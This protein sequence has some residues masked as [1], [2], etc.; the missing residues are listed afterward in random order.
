MADKKIKNKKASAKYKKY[1]AD[2]K[3]KPNCPKCG[4]GIFLAE[5]KGQADVRHLR[6]YCV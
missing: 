1:S 5:H 3:R 2:G 6:I 4:P